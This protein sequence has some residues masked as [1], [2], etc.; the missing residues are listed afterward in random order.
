MMK[1]GMSWGLVVLVTAGLG[2]AQET[3]KKTKAA[4][5][6]EDAPPVQR[7]KAGIEWVTLPGGSFKMGSRQGQDDEKP[8]HKVTIESFQMA[9]T[10]VTNKQYQ[11]CVRARACTAPAA[12]AASFK[13]DD[14][15]VVCVDW[16]QAQAFSKWVGGRL[17]TEAEW[18]YAA[19]SAGK[20]WR[21]PWGN[22]AA[23][24]A[25][26][27]ISGCG[28][29]TAPVCSKPAGNTQ[30]G[31]CDMAG[32]A[33]EWVQDWYHGSYR[34][35]PRDG[36]AWGS[37]TGSVRVDRGGSWGHFAADARSA[38]RGYAGPGL[39]VNLLGFRSAKDIPSR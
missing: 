2:L 7:G 30:Q 6:V 39:R 36:S 17:P 31:L 8:R 14:Q 4:P 29:A 35:A 22:E 1:I 5:G 10:L 27:V 12:A 23:T 19:R 18:E 15:P 3:P 21:Y 20:N 37:P 11:A 28:S 25:R 24:C 13:G 33:W 32:N 26:A 16:N 38:G 34:G 9:K